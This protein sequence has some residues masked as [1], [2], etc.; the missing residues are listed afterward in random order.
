[1]SAAGPVPSTSADEPV[2]QYQAVQKA[3]IQVHRTY[4]V[5]GTRVGAA[6]AYN[7]PVFESPRGV[8]A[9]EVR[10]VAVDPVRCIKLVVEG[11]PTTLESPLAERSLTA[12]VGTS[13][14][15]PRTQR[16][17][18]HQ[19][20]QIAT[21]SSGFTDIWWEDVVGALLNGDRTLVTWDWNGTCALG[22][23]TDGYWRWRDS[24]GWYLYKNGGS[25]DT[26]CDRHQGST[27]SEFRNGSFCRPDVVITEYYYVQFRGYFDG[28]YGGS[29]SSDTLYECAPVYRYG[30]VVKTS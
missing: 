27:Y 17:P 13:G 18:G 21:R 8:E 7:Y 28:T 22:G 15:A 29:S 9:W 5:T 6:C 24:T 4:T 26:A 12:Q 30:R 19:R 20:P 25:Q 14:L 2:F 11:I 10:D 23:A 1:M 16:G 3:P